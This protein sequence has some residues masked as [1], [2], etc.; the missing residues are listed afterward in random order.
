[1]SQ[2]RYLQEA[3]AAV[4]GTDLGSADQPSAADGPALVTTDTGMPYTSL[5]IL[6]STAS[7]EC[8]YLLIG[9]EALDIGYTALDFGSQHCNSGTI[10]G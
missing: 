2:Q 5:E 6:S 1:M 8:Q 7:S 9:Y 3:Q 10:Q 4:Q